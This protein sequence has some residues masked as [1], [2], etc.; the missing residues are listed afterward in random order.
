MFLALA[1][2]DRINVLR[3]EKQD[4]L[5]KALAADKYANTV[6]KEAN[7]T[8]LDALKLSEQN[9]RTKDA[10]ILS[11]SHE[12][13]TPLNAIGAS[14][15][16]LKDA[17]GDEAR[18]LFQYIQFGADRL[19]AQ[20][21]NILLLAETDQR[22]VIPH[23]RE[24]MLDSLL[25]QLK[26]SNQSYLYQK[27]V[28]LKVAVVPNM[29]KQF[30]GDEHL[31]ASM[32]APVVDNACKYTEQGSVEISVD[33]R[34]AQGVDEK[35]QLLVFIKDTGPG[36]NEELQT[37]IFN[38]FVQASTGY[39][40]THEGMGL[41]LSISQR[42]AK[43]L[44]AAIDLESEEGQGSCF[45]FCIPIECVY[46]DPNVIKG[47]FRANGHAL[48]VE[49]N[50]VNAKVLGALLRKLGLTMDLASNGKEALELPNL[51]SYDVIFMDLQMPV[52]DGFLAT[53]ALR[54][55]GVTCPIIAV[56]ANTDYQAR[57]KCWDVGMND[58]LGKPVR[59]DL[60]Q[61]ALNR[62][63]AKQAV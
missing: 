24:F 9:Q 60:L 4:A 18:E 31:I 16:Q 11:V 27:P 56:T 8:L 37:D 52:M 49:D 2:A 6:L 19:S 35:N 1:L 47:D 43:I 58:F 44:N 57:V 40:R 28:E 14:L 29:P 59:K 45:S 7:E 17:T 46:E 22:E 20:V 33:F 26:N 5:E 34:R 32:L 48:V 42:L 15:D 54:Q 50:N 51:H 23:N 55:L 41:G 3:K 62:W 30:I 38:P 13:R 21:E 10:F 39:Q 63:V 53:T 61:H 12:L 25:D 36:I